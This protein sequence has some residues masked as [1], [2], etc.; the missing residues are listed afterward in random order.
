MK[1]FGQSWPVLGIRM[2]KQQWSTA[3]GLLTS[4]GLSPFVPV[5]LTDNSQQILQPGWDQERTLTVVPFLLQLSRR[6]PRGSARPS[7]SSRRP[8]WLAVA[9]WAISWVFICLSC[10]WSTN[11]QFAVAVL[12]LHDQWWS[13][14]ASAGGSL[15]RVGGTVGLGV[16]P[17][18]DWR[19]SW[20]SSWAQR[21]RFLGMSTS[22]AVPQ[23]PDQQKPGA[24]FWVGA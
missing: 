3:N 21:A 5:L 4:I 10:Q 12:L 6:V 2:Q 9:S 17:A 1:H 24:S 23:C 19:R 11:Y 18:T 7:D 14:W 8:S 20:A 13:W 15:W 22:S 16:L